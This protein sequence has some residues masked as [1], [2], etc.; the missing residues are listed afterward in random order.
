MTA[1][2]PLQEPLHLCESPGL[3]LSNR[4]PVTQLLGP[5]VSGITQ[6]SI[7]FTIFVG[8]LI[9]TSARLRSFGV[10]GVSAIGT[11]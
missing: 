2:E 10:R 5:V 8:I 7:L 6:V 3:N 11:A 4:I 9:V 1:L